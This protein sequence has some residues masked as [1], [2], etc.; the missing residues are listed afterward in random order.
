MN[1]VHP[2]VTRNKDGI[3]QV[4]IPG[5]IST[6]GQDVESIASAQEDAETW[7]KRVYSG[8][9]HVHRLGEQASGL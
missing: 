5:R 6:P 2:L 1:L 7:L 3:L 8:E 9:S 4:V